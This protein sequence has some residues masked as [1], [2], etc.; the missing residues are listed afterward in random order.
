[1]K[2]HIR[3]RS[4]GRWGIVIERRDPVTGA[5]RRKGHSFKGTKRQAQD[6]CARLISEMRS[7]TYL[8]PSKVTMAQHLERWLDHVKSQVSPRT[9]E[10]YCEIV[11]KNIIPSLGAIHTPNI[12][13]RLIQSICRTVVRPN[14]TSSSHDATMYE[15]S[16]GGDPWVCS[17]ATPRGN[18]PH[19]A[20]ARPRPV[21][22]QA[23][24]GRSRRGPS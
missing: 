11:R 6:E 14:A 12:P 16:A 18:S 7:G 24:F 15:T 20:P 9:H 1:M 17:A 4:P 13:V 21:A 2:G 19:R 5:R 23:S 22:W 3:E 10:R 8:E